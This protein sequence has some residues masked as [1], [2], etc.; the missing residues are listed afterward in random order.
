MDK[1]LVHE[2]KQASLPFYTA[3]TG[4]QHWFWGTRH[5]VWTWGDF[6]EGHNAANWKCYFFVIRMIHITFIPSETPHWNAKAAN[7]NRILIFPSTCFFTW[8][9]FVKSIFFKFPSI[10]L[11]LFSRQTDIYANSCKNCFLSWNLKNFKTR[12]TLLI[13]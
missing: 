10:I 6:Y 8:K 3:E 4:S 5:S 9:R 12:S 2:K 11:W 7:T 13:F 1:H